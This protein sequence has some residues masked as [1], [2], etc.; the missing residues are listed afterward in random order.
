MREQHRGA[1]K[2]IGAIMFGGGMWAV[3]KGGY[4]SKNKFEALRKEEEEEEEEE[5]EENYF[6]G[7]LI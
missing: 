4:E 7:N 1:R 3:R 5:K 6:L 2:N